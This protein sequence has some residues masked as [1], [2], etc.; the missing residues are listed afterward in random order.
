M[1]GSTDLEHE[2]LVVLVDEEDHDLGAMGKLEAH[3]SGALHR[4][5]SVFIFNSDGS[6]LLQRRALTKYHSAGLWAN[7]CCGHP[8]PGEDIVR[9]AGRRVK[10]ELRM[11]IL[12]HPRF[13]FRYRATFENGLIE[14][15]LDHVLFATSDEPSTPDPSE[16]EAVRRIAPEELTLE[17]SDHPERFAVWLRTCWHQVLAARKADMGHFP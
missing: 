6:V 2:P 16:V 8:L 13:K 5:F 1:T 4:A 3:R 7:A 12:P 10:E 9:A 17:L 14:N 15:E 11:S